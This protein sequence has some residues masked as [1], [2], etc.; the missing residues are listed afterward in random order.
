M[1]GGYMRNPVI[2]MWWR[3]GRQEVIPLP[4][5]L[6]YDQTWSLWSLVLSPPWSVSLA[7]LDIHTLCCPIQPE[8]FTGAP[9]RL[10]TAPTE[11]LHLRCH[12]EEAD[13]ISPEYRSLESSASGNKT[14]SFI[15]SQP[16]LIPPPPLPPQGKP[17]S[18]SWYA[19][20]NPRR[21]LGM[22]FTSKVL[23]ILNKVAIYI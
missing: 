15:L 11:I 5:L 1:T 10:C 18:V 2:I 13:P 14:V 22:R 6:R 9:G 12:V 3:R 17:N 20:A 19:S 23:N 7:E 21:W 8:T 4:S 16:L